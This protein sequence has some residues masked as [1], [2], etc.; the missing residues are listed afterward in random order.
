MEMI[1]V[2]AVIAILAGAAIPK[3]A[4]MNPP[5]ST[6]GARRLAADIRFAQRLATTVHLPCGLMV[7][8]PFTYTVWK[9]TTATPAVDPL[10]Q[11]PMLVDLS[12]SFGSVTISPSNGA[13]TFDTRG[14]PAAGFTAAFTVGTHGVAVAAETGEA[15][16]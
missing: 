9:G 2:I 8:G 7:T 5:C 14:R 3:Y 1:V 10:T 6:G 16:Y 4:S 13:V 15:R 12:A 11:Q